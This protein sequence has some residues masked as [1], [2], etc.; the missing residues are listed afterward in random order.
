ME[1]EKKYLVNYMPEEIANAHVKVIEQ[2]YLSVN[3]VVRIRKSNNRYILTYK[4]H[5]NIDV[6]E[7]SD[8]CM[9]NEVELPLT[10]DSY[11]HLKTKADGMIISKKRY[12]IPLAIYSSEYGK[13]KAE[14]D[15]FYGDL[16]GLVFVEVEFDNVVQAQ[17]F[18]PP[19]WFGKDVSEDGRYRNSFLSNI[20]NRE[21]FLEVFGSII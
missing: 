17:N 11:E 4:S 10:K 12:N 8:I 20:N 6:N 18:V 16:Q 19:D 13:L 15:V 2:A 14:L 9:S 7:F 1:I 3:P 21:E 5:D